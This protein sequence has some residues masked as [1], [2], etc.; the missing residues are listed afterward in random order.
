MLSSDT[1]RVPGAG[2][3]VPSVGADFWRKNVKGRR[4]TDRG[5]ADTYVGLPVFE[6]P[7][8]G[9]FAQEALEILG[10]RERIGVGQ[11]GRSLPHMEDIDR[12]GAF[13]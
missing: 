6:L 3:D 2:S 8:C 4:A 7:V 13:G 12:L 1:T 9:P 10:Q 5:T 11:L